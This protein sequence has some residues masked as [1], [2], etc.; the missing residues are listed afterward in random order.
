MA[1]GIAGA[2]DGVEAIP[3]D[4][5]E[6]VRAA[7]PPPDLRQVALELTELVETRHARARRNLDDVE[8]LLAAEEP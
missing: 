5:I 8:S 7:N 1:G 3:E 2:L 4:W 6:A